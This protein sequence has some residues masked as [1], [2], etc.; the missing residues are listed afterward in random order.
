MCHSR[1]P[2]CT[3]CNWTQLPDLL[4]PEKLHAIPCAVG[5]IIAFP[6]EASFTAIV[7][8]LTIRQAIPS[9]AKHE[10]EVWTVGLEK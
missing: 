4:S 5:W 7:Y 6:G 1:L 8:E 9:Q 3:P 2:L 10:G